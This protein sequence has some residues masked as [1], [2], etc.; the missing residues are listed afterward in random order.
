MLRKK[1]PTVDKNKGKCAVIFKRLM[2]NVNDPTNILLWQDQYILNTNPF[3][4]VLGAN[5]GRWCAWL[6]ACSSNDESEHFDRSS[7]FVQKTS[8]SRESGL[9]QTVERYLTERW[10]RIL[11]FYK[12]LFGN[13]SIFF[14]SNSP[15]TLRVYQPLTLISIPSLASKAR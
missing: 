14:I 5:M 12:H 7:L 9:L 15:K 10:Q 8:K 13:I 6:H 3:S 1:F 2:I 11:I 4:W